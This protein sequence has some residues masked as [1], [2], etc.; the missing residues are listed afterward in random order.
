MKGA[1]KRVILAALA[2]LFMVG[3]LSSCSTST[4][5]YSGYHELESLEIIRAIC[6]DSAEDGVL[7]SVD[8]GLGLDE[9]EPQMYSSQKATISLALEYLQKT[10]MGKECVYSHAEHLVL[11]EEAAQ[12]GIAAYLD[13]V[14]RATEMRL[15]TNIF[16]VKGDTAQNLLTSVASEKTSATDMLLNVKASIDKMGLGKV[17]SCGDVS[18]E[19]EKTG[20]A[21]VAAIE[22]RETDELSE[23]GGEKVIVPVGMGVIVDG[24]LVDYVLN[25]EAKGASMLMNKLENDNIDI[26]LDG[27]KIVLGMTEAKV[28]YH[29]NFN[30]DTLE[31][32]DVLAKVELNIIEVDGGIDVLD[33]NVREE[34]QA[35]VNNILTQRMRDALVH[36][37]ALQEDY[38]GIGEKIEMAAPAKFARISEEWP[39][40]FTD[41]PFTIAVESEVERTYEISLPIT[42]RGEESGIGREK[43]N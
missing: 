12:E 30:D 32:V 28:H 37:Q 43:E 25:E 11:G 27:G 17:F 1:F 26:D 2:A 23:T 29:P 4:A 13:Y 10:P 38:L 36:S 6:V 31:S 22:L 5:L 3:S 39:A 16:V 7:V 21:L 18:V 8:T 41:I 20:N 35:E 24:V 14:A 19:L 42:V 15:E 34:M 9:K 40:L 33:D